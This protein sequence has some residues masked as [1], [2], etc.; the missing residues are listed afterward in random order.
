MNSLPLKSFYFFGNFF[1][2][3]SVFLFAGMIYFAADSWHFLKNSM[4]AGVII[5]YVILS[6]VF[7]LLG[8]IFLCLH[9][10]NKK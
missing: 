1:P 4:D 8:S 10:K 2:G 9:K 3:V 5:A 7:V 6:I